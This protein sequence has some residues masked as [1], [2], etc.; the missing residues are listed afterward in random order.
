MSAAIVI[1]DA[2]IDLAAFRVMGES[3]YPI[4]AQ[5]VPYGAELRP[6]LQAFLS[7]VLASGGAVAPQAPAAADIVALLHLVRS[8]GDAR[9][10]GNRD[11][12]AGWIRQ[13]ESTLAAPAAASTAGQADARIEKLVSLANS[14]V[15]NTAA[16]QPLSNACR[17]DIRLV[18][19]IAFKLATKGGA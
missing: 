10:D 3:T 16:G 1:T 15:N 13:I 14:L 5:N 6:F 19:D 18:C 8:Y 4:L 12:A 11:R 7:D 9:V 2:Q 17:M